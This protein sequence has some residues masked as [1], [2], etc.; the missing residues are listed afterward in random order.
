MGRVEAVSIAAESGAALSWEES[1][2]VSLVSLLLLQATITAENNRAAMRALEIDLR[3]TLFIITGL[4]Y[5][6]TQ[7]LSYIIAL[8]E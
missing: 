6:D 2:A 3:A 1:V 5:K 7:Y 4:E 8:S